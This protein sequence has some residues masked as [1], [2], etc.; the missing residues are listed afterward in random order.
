MQEGIKKMLTLDDRT[1]LSPRL[2][3]LNIHLSEYSFANLF[4]FR[5]KHHYKVVQLEG[6]IFVQG[7]TYDGVEILIPT[8]IPE[9]D[10]SKKLIEKGFTFYPIPEQWLDRFP[11]EC[12][13]I[14]REEDNDYLFQ[15]EKIATYAG[16]TL[17]SKRNLVAQFERDNKAEIVPLTKP[18]IEDAFEVLEEWTRFSDN[19]ED[20]SSECKEALEYIEELSLTGFLFYVEKKPIAFLAGEELTDDVYIIHFAKGLRQYKGV[21]PYIYQQCAKRLPKKYVML[22]FE[23]DLGLPN[24]RQAK[25]SFHPDSY[26]KKFRLNLLKLS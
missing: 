9:L 17:S 13:F 2:K 22:N 4:L 21:Y 19:S 10:R 3:S 11:K 5:K 16:R 15:R 7:F 18:F 12:L 24:L 23:Q 20:D 1:L 6:E 26:G 14:N 8:S 25:H